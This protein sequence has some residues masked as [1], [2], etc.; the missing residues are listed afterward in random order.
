MYLF[1]VR[2][3]LRTFD[4][5]RRDAIAFSIASEAA[6]GSQCNPPKAA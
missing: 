6:A 4:E 2:R 3:R 1:P 5:R